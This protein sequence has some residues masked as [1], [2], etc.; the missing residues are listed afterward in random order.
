MEFFIIVPICV[1]LILIQIPQLFHSSPA[2]ST[3]PLPSHDK[4]KTS[5][6]MISITRCWSLFLFFLFFLLTC[7]ESRMTPLISLIILLLI[8]SGYFIEYHPTAQLLFHLT[9][10]C[11]WI[12]C[13]DLY[14][15]TSFDQQTH[16]YHFFDM[17]WLVAVYLTTSIVIRAQLGQKWQLHSVPHMFLGIPLLCFYYWGLEMPICGLVETAF[18]SCELMNSPPHCFHETEFE[19]QYRLFGV[20]VIVLL[21]VVYGQIMISFLP[22]PSQGRGRVEGEDEQQQEEERRQEQAQRQQQHG[23][24]CDGST[25]LPFGRKRRSISGVESQREH[26]NSHD[27]SVSTVIVS[28]SPSRP[29]AVCSDTVQIHTHEVPFHHHS[30]QQTSAS[31]SRSPSITPDHF[32]PSS[33]SYSCELG[34]YTSDILLRLPTI[35]ESATSASFWSS[36]VSFQPNLL[37][38]QLQFPSHSLKTERVIERGASVT[39]TAQRE[40]MRCSS[41]SLHNQRSSQRILRNPMATT[42]VISSPLD[43]GVAMGGTFID[44]VR[45]GSGSS[46]E[47][48]SSSSTLDFYPRPSCSRTVLSSLSTSSSSPVIPPSVSFSSASTIS[49]GCSDQV[50]HS[51]APPVSAPTPG[52]VISEEEAFEIV[53]RRLHCCKTKR[54]H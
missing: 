28:S 8:T 38:S 16:F 22:E 51:A 10:S 18:F 5:S 19:N 44:K 48:A 34:N 3:S 17:K 26:G 50:P 41:N 24:E 14:F 54:A 39:A 31:V 20:G 11:S 46:V 37:H 40:K 42:S 2:S 49:I 13:F 30:S 47:S 12:G 35:L 52:S 15:R 27:R 36:L 23:G 29:S 1:G 25:Q 6:H 43:C 7:C 4:D 45:S 9:S 21:H 33:S 53:Q 32:S